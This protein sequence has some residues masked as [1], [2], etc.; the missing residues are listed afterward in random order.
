MISNYIN[1]WQKLDANVD[2]LS[3]NPKETHLNL[4][5]DYSK[6][7]AVKIVSKNN[8]FPAGVYDVKFR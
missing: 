2:I 7:M 1:W 6:R 5:E 8:D 3:V 4:D